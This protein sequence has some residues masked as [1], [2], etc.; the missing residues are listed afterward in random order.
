MIDH[1]PGWIGFEHWEVPYMFHHVV[2]NKIDLGKISDNGGR[3]EL[4]IEPQR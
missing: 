2:R 1:A 4:P 3:F